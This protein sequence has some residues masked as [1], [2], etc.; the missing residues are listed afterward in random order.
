[1]QSIK[2]PF[3]CGFITTEIGKY[4]TNNEILNL[5]ASGVVTNETIKSAFFELFGINETIKKTID[6]DDTYMREM[7]KCN[8][9]NPRI[10]TY[11][12]PLKGLKLWWEQIKWIV[13]VENEIDKNIGNIFKRRNAIIQSSIETLKG[14][15]VTNQGTIWFGHWIKQRDLLTSF[16]KEIKERNES[17]NKFKQEKSSTLINKVSCFFLKKILKKYYKHSEEVKMDSFDKSWFLKR[18][19]PN[20]FNS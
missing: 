6:Y 2:S 17:Y 11:K 9:N 5:A 8:T 19:P 13:G 12:I 3:E 10:Y 7:I 20:R 16:E 4:L 14:V 1:M 15:E 18:C